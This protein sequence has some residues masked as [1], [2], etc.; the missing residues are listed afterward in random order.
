[1][2]VDRCGVTNCPEGLV[3]QSCNSAVRQRLQMTTVAAATFEYH[4]S[5]C[6]SGGAQQ[7]SLVVLLRIKIDDQQQWFLLSAAN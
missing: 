3:E 4:L 1:M 7:Y 5:F 6:L 2:A